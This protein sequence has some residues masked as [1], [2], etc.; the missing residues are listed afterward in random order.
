MFSECISIPTTS[1]LDCGLYT[2]GV[3][4][5]LKSCLTPE[6]LF[7]TFDACS[8]LPGDT[9]AWLTGMSGCRENLHRF[10]KVAAVRC[11]L[12]FTQGRL[13]QRS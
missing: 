13:L 9:I 11:A 10:E 8:Q 6:G 12:K 1:R 5:R 2:H 7:A 3:K 4:R